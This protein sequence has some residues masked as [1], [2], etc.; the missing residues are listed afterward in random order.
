MKSSTTEQGKGKHRKVKGKIKET[1][2][3]KSRVKVGRP[4]QDRQPPAETKRDIPTLRIAMEGMPVEPEQVSLGMYE[5]WF[6]IMRNCS[7]MIADSNRM[8]LSSL[9]NFMDTGQRG[10]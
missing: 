7:Y 3:L 5:G 10:R 4:Q 9:S 1:T 2:K 6:Q 8:L